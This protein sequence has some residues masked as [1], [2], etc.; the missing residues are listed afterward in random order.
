LRREENFLEDDFKREGV[1]QS[2]N[3][4]WKCQFELAEDEGQLVIRPSL[5]SRI[6]FYNPL[7]EGKRPDGQLMSPDEEAQNW[8]SYIH[9]A[10][11]KDEKDALEFANNWG[12]LG[13]WGIE[14]YRWAALLFPQRKAKKEFLEK[15]HSLWYEWAI[16][17]GTLY[18]QYVCYQEPVL[19]FLEA[20]KSYQK[21]I[22]KLA[23]EQEKEP[24]GLHLHGLVSYGLELRW[25]P[26]EK[27]WELGWTYDSLYNAVYLQAALNLAGGAYG[28]RR[29][30]WAKCG[31][32]FLAK[33]EKDRFCSYRCQNNFFATESKMKK[34]VRKLWEECKLL[35]EIMQATGL[36][37]EKIQQWLKC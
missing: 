20:V 23:C 18:P 33:H 17:K 14:P 35:D 9:L 5:D 24:G 34:L 37:A 8:S 26:E 36:P 15:E 2:R 21:W 1:L 25:E 19:L 16:P 28:F 32:S 22:D 7:K 13:L 10:R 12:L 4:W 29:C 31:R 11:V 30:K 27:R 3:L 6:E